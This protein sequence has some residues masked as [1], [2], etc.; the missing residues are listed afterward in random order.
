[1]VQ[2]LSQMSTIVKKMPQPTVPLQLM[3]IFSELFHVLAFDICQSIREV[4]TRIQVCLDNYVFSI[5]NPEAIPLK[6]IRTETVAEGM[7]EIFSHTGIP[8]KL[9]TDQGKQFMGKLNKQLCQ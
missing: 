3:P 8:K 2:S 9:L 6:D 1:M 7:L 4:T 5:E